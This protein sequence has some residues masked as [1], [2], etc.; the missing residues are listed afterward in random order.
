MSMPKLMVV[1]DSH[2]IRLSMQKTLSKAGYEVITAS[3]GIEAIERLEES[4]A[5]IVL[6]VNMPG[7]DG[8]GVCEKLRELGSNYDDLPVVFLTSMKSKAL[9]MLGQEFGAY[10]QKPV[11]EDE[12]LSVIAEQ[13]EKSSWRQFA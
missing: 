11:A 6:D 1:D 3:D 7:L 12:L 2:S 9:Q 13:L 8:Y 5:L 10:L 4:P